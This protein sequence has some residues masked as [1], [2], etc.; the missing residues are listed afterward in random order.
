MR[1][2]AESSVWKRFA[3]SCDL[4]GFYRSKSHE[5]LYR[6]Q[7]FCPLGVLQDAGLHGVRHHGRHLGAGEG[8]LALE[9]AGAV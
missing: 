9:R 3:H 7:A 2:A 1:R 5:C 4:L 6:F 8:A